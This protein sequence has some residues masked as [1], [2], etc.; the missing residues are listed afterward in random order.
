[1]PLPVELVAPL[2]S[3][4]YGHWT[5]PPEI[6]DEA[7]RLP[8]PPIPR[9][10]QGPTTSRRSDRAPPRPRSSATHPMACN[11][12]ATQAVS[13]PT[14]VSSGR[15]DA[16]GPTVCARTRMRSRRIRAAR[17]VTQRVRV[18]R[19]AASASSAQQPSARGHHR[20]RESCRAS[21]SSGH[22][23]HRC[24]PR[25]PQFTRPRRPARRLVALDEA[26]PAVLE[27]S[28]RGDG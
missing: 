18:P 3:R 14:R 21:C 28:P 10:R 5:P 15:R 1:M 24:E 25:L 6:L 7:G 11:A 19:R 9:R 22:S 12:S 20:V 26:P 23:A 13:R 17:R 4:L 2:T 27:A 16:P 8:R